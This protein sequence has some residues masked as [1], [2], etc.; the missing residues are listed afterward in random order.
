MLHKTKTYTCIAQVYVFHV[1]PLQLDRNS[2]FQEFAELSGIHSF[3][4]HKTL[5]YWQGDHQ[6]DHFNEETHDRNTA[7]ISTFAYPRCA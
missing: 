4:I 7:S 6:E 3:F 1:L 5:N 2:R